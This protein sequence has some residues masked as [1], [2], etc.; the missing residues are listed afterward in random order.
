MNKWCSPD[1]EGRRIQKLD[2]LTIQW[3]MRGETPLE[4]PSAEFL[5]VCLYE[6][7]E[8]FSTVEYFDVSIYL[9]FFTQWLH[10]ISL[11]NVSVNPHY[12]ENYFIV[13]IL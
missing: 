12:Y 5:P 2:K 4:P 6:C 11:T 13:Y 1:D 10:E 7:P 8:N 3:C 9:R